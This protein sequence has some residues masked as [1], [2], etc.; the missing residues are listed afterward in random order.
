MA[1][2]VARGQASAMTIS[3]G[4]MNTARDRARPELLWYIRHAAVLERWPVLEEPWARRI[5]ERRV[6]A[7]RPRDTVYLH[8]VGR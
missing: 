7:E 8:G 5:E 2:A 3:A 4:S 6:E 1:V